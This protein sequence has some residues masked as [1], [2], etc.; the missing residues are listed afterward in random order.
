ML[1]KTEPACFHFSSSNCV[2]CAGSQNEAPQGILL[3]VTDSWL[4]GWLAGK[5]SL[6]ANPGYEV[7]QGRLVGSR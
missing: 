5:Y 2:Y 4:A 7:A 3:E 1:C 6:L